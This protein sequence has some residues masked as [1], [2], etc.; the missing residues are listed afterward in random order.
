[1]FH[2]FSSVQVSPLGACC[3]RA[4][5]VRAL[6]LDLGAQALEVA[7]HDRDRELPPCAGR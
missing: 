3:R 1:M 4:R 5:D 7:V 6:E 2:I